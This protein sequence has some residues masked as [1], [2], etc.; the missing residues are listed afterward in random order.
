MDDTFKVL[1]EIGFSDYEA[2][3]YVALL[4]KS[5]SNGYNVAKQSGIPRA[6]IYEC[7]ERLLARGAVARIES[8]DQKTTLFAPTDPVQLFDQMQKQTSMVFQKAREAIENL[9]TDNR[10]VEI[11]WRVR[12]N[13]DLVTRGQELT[14]ES[15]VS[16]HVAIWAEEFEALFDNLIEAAKRG[17]KIALVLYSKHK[18]LKDLQNLKTGAILHGRSKRHAIPTMGR[19]FALVSDREK[20][21]TGSIFSEKEVE[22]V[23]TLNRGL[24][25]NVIDLVNHEI[26]IE[27]IMQEVGKPVS[28]VFGKNL[29]KLDAF[30]PLKK[31]GK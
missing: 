3:A 15:T 27:R 2:R 9:Q 7:L 29:E 5:P 1:T 16:L 26:Y 4:N 28:D 17:V 6:K 25:T 12:S 23:F 8:T 18:G 20:C 22:G 30:D 19:Q 24:V 10:S 11:L 14:S 21:I 31:V 13:K